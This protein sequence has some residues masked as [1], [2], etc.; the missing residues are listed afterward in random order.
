MLGLLA[1]MSKDEYG[2][3]PATALSPS[4]DHAASLL[5]DL[6]LVA[7]VSEY[8][9]GYRLTG[10]GYDALAKGTLTDVR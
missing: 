6:E 1:R 9:Y 3:L 10:K 5:E 2:R 8:P 7:W 4:D